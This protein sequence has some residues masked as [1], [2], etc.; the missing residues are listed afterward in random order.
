MLRYHGG[1]GYASSYLCFPGKNL[2]SVII[3]RSSGVVSASSSNRSA[4]MFKQSEVCCFLLIH[5]CPLWTILLHSWYKHYQARVYHFESW[6][7]CSTLVLWGCYLLPIP[8]NHLIWLI[9]SLGNFDSQSAP[10]AWVSQVVCIFFIL[11]EPLKHDPFSLSEYI[12][13]QSIN[14]S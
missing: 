13:W 14:K 12:T 1:N 9:L 8:L 10:R 6:V 11:F 4:S 7:A 2:F 3:T 5:H